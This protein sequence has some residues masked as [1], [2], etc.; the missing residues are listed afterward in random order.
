[1]VV[2]LAA[3]VLLAACGSSAADDRL[4]GLSG[5][6]DGG[7]HGGVHADDADTSATA[8]P[9]DPVPREPLGPDEEFLTVGVP[10]GPYTPQPRNGAATTTAASRWTQA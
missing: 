8:S 6:E 5:S 2:V 4:A 10:D 7:S 1:V 9:E 3:L